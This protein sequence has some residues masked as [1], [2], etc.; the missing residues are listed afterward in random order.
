[1]P[2]L[3]CAWTCPQGGGQLWIPSWDHPQVCEGKRGQIL[4]VTGSAPSRAA[5]CMGTPLIPGTVR[6]CGVCT[7]HG[8][9]CVGCPPPS[10][11]GMGLFC[12]TQALRF[13]LLGCEPALRS[14][15]DEL[16]EVAEGVPAHPS[17]LAQTTMAR[18]L[19]LPAGPRG[20]P[21]CHFPAVSL[22]PSCPLLSL[23]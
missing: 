14:P 22:S 6:G 8:D 19:L 7:G 4:F 5:D 11:L 17:S 13:V 10:C 9:G 16:V 21:G 1:M 15:Q 20:P 12:P 2:H 23:M 3:G 18:A